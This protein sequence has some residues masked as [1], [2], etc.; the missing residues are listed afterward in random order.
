MTKFCKTRVPAELNV[1]IGVATNDN[2]AKEIGI[3]V[4]YEMCQELLKKEVTSCLHFYTLN[5]ANV[6]C[7]IV[8][9]L[10]ETFT[11]TSN[12]KSIK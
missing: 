11:F 6:T 9:K 3:E 7:G 10:Q 5:M 8:E 2:E 4:G 12:S 1:R